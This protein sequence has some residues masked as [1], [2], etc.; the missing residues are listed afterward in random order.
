MNEIFLVFQALYFLPLLLYKLGKEDQPDV[1]QRL[2][3]TVPQ[4]A[5]HKV[6]MTTCYSVKTVH[7]VLWVYCSHKK[8]WSGKLWFSKHFLCFFCGCSYSKE[9]QGVFKEIIYLNF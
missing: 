8:M 6:P 9:E 3:Y 7:S 2:L 1:K 4:L 5:T